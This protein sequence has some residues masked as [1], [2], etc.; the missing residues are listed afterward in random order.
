MIGRPAG[1]GSFIKAGP[2]LHCERDQGK[3]QDL[4]FFLL[5]GPGQSKVDERE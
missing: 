5:R 3:E 4:W 1:K 2:F